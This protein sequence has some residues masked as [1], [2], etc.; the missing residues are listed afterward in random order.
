LEKVLKK[1]AEEQKASQARVQDLSSKKP[2]LRVATNP[3]RPK[4]PSLLVEEVQDTAQGRKMERT[5]VNPSASDA[6]KLERMRAK[7]VKEAQAAR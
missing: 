2:V 3:N 6:V 4:G 7:E 5:N 1:Q